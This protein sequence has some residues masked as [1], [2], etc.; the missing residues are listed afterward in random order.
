MKKFASLLIVA[1]LMMVMAT[2]ALAE[3]AY[4]AET[5][6]ISGSYTADGN[7]EIWV[8]GELAGGSKLNVP[9]E[10]GKTYTIDVFV[11]GKKVATETVTTG[12]KP[13]AEPTVAPTAEPTAVPTAEP[14]A[15][16]TAV[17]TAEPTAVPTAVP[18]AEPTVAPTAVPTAV[19]TVAPTAEPEPTKKPSGSKSSDVPKTG[20]N[21]TVVIGVVALMA[22]AAVVLA[23]RKVIRNH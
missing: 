5:G 12:A 4:N 10:A 21:T 9:A 8:N 16:P 6:R 19:P 13:T 17:P 3:F 14:T 15:E 18:T 2:S 20:E 1:L 22:V 11:D 23:S 7:V